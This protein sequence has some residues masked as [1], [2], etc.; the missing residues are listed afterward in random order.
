MAKASVMILLII[1][2]NAFLWVGNLTYNFNGVNSDILD[3]FVD[4]PDD[5]RTGQISRDDTANE[6][7]YNNGSVNANTP[8]DK[9]SISSGAGA[10][11]FD[12]GLLE[13]TSFLW[14]TIL[15]LWDLLTLSLTFW[16]TI[17]SIDFVTAFLL[18]LPFGI[19]YMFAVFSIWSKYEW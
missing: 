12:K 10:G 7:I 6:G 1:C 9:I 15:L 5:I 14:N 17:P 3:R 2:I 19:M 8:R 18:S 16:Y 4:M 11:D 13:S